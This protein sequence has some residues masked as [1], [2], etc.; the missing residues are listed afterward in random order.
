ML[1]HW[2]SMYALDQIS[3]FILW[4]LGEE[5]EEELLLQPQFT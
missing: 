3:Q 1:V 5:E 2:M 4:V